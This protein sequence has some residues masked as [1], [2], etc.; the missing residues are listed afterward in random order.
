MQ[1]DENL[2]VTGQGADTDDGQSGAGEANLAGETPK[3]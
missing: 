3:T 1:Q 2:R